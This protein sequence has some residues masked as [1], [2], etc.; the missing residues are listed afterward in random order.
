MKVC[1]WGGAGGRG[2]R[3][4]DG[5]DQDELHKCMTLSKNKQFLKEF[6]VFL[7]S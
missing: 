7:K 2:E 3:E 1:V 6:G 5:C 4:M